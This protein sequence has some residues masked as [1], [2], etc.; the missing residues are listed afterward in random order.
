MN[1]ASF[2][3]LLLLAPLGGRAAVVPTSD[4]S[5]TFLLRMQS[6][7][8]AWRSTS[9]GAFRDGRA[10]TPHVLR[11]LAHID[12]PSLDQTKEKAVRWLLLRRK[13]LFDSFPVHAASALLE[14]ATRMDSLTPLGV[15]AVKRLLTLQTSSGGWSYSPLPVIP[16]TPLAPMQQANL[17]ATAIAID[18]LRAAGTA[19]DAIARALP[20]VRRCQ[21]HDSDDP[22]F[23]DGG[24][25]QMP[26]DPTRNKAGR[27]GTDRSGTLR[28]RS[29]AA[30][31]AD[32]MRCLLSA[33]H[34]SPRISAARAWLDDFHWRPA[35]S[36]V[37]PRDLV[38]YAAR[39][40]AATAAL[41][42][43]STAALESVRDNLP[44]S[45]RPNGHWEN[46][47]GEMRENCQLVASAL[48]L[49]AIQLGR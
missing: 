26:L 41:D 32:G 5:L 47:A 17:S 28:F 13:D 22:A 33:R 44:K 18:G 39:S 2:L 24:F 19:G 23:D 49:E 36:A 15:T 12:D 10:L 25:F 46:P 37:S 16:G 45:R 43:K 30:A 38:Y 1:R 20:F 11:C 42:G 9:Y 29:Y 27:V 3:R 14:A 31:T 7:D 21:N 35:G 4:P 48:A 8:G 34:D 40:I 6:D